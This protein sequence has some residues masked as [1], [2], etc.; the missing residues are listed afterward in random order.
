MTTPLDLAAVAA[1]AFMTAMGTDAW[2]AVRERIAR[3]L[4]RHTE[5]ALEQTV[6]VR[7]DAFARD[8]EALPEGQRPGTVPVYTASIARD[9]EPVAEIPAAAAELAE[10]AAQVAPAMAGGGAD[11]RGL[12]I[13]HIKPDGDFNFGGNSNTVIRRD[14]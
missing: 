3:L 2:P 6:L 13:H 7:M 4:H 11:N 12:H 5:P 14:A 1:G 8:L 10:L 9:L